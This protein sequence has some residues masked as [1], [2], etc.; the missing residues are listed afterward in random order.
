ME[1]VELQMPIRL[2]G[3][4]TGMDTDTLIKQMMQAHRVPIDRMKQKQQTITWQRDAYRE[5]NTLMAQL[6]DTITSLR[7]E[8]TTN[9]KKVTTGTDAVSATASASTS[10]GSYALTVHQMASAAKITGNTV[11]TTTGPLN[12]AGS[13]VLT[14]NGVDVTFNQNSTANDVVNALNAKTADT[15]VKASFDAVTQRVT[16]TSTKM[17]STS[18]INI[19][20]TSGDASLLTNLNLPTTSATGQQAIVD[21]NG[22][23]GLTFESNSFTVEGVNFTLKPTASATF[24]MNV[25]VA[26]SADTDAVFNSIKSFVE[27]YNEVID[28]VHKKTH[29]ARYRDF[30]PLTDD[31]RKDMKEDEI[32]L[33]EEKA[34]SGMLRNDATM[35]SA[36]DKMRIALMNPVTGLPAGAYNTL[37]DIGITTTPPG[38]LAYREN[39]KLYLDENKLREALG[40]NPE[41]VSDLLTKGYADRLY[42][43]IDLTVT[44]LTKMA[45]SS[46][47]LSDSSTLGTQLRDLDKQI[48]IKN[49]GLKAYEDKYYKQ[50]ASLETAIQTMNSQ[51]AWLSQ[52]FSGM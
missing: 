26:V 30:Q 24:P 19:A 14:V 11:S 37:S 35:N 5:M 46:A 45:G 7:F 40:N 9:A 2:T 12:T 13:T 17:G 1:R 34:K 21:Y 25:N 28:K 23:S 51:S 3:M 44:R 29:E 10:V 18:T 33:W 20:H 48:S 4:A 16:L 52:Q 41:Q 47:V 22:V 49:S 36:L 32:K 50:F 42:K 6:R 8:S 27:K 38:Q 43:E 31:Q 39:G 15:G